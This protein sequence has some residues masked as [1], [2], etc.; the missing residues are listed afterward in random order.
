MMRPAALGNPIV[1]I[2]PRRYS[3][4]IDGKQVSWF[5]SEITGETGG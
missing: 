2:K 4:R 3:R 5:A 1:R